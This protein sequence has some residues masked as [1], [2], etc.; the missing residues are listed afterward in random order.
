MKQPGEL[1]KLFYSNRGNAAKTVRIFLKNHRVGRGPCSPKSVHKLVKKIRCT[2]DRPWS[3]QLSIPTQGVAEVH[4]IITA[5]P[6][7]TTR[8]AVWSLDLPP[9]HSSA[10]CLWMFP[11]RFQCVQIFLLGC[12]QLCGD[13][14]YFFLNRYDEDDRLPLWILWTDEEHFF[15]IRSVNTKNY[16]HW[17]DKNPHHVVP[18]PLHESKMTVWCGITNTFVFGFFDEVTFRSIKS[19][20]VTSD[21][22]KSMLW[23]YVIPEL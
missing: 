7:Y 12:E 8:S 5:G 15:L 20:S 19:C 10:L 16:I 1:M 17:A 14:T 2:S 6:S 22:Y 9:K 23:K 11:Y 18:V 13:F 21:W 3:G 4:H